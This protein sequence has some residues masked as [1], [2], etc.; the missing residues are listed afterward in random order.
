MEELIKIEKDGNGG[1]AVSARELHAFLGATERFGAWFDRQKQ[2]GFDENLDYSGCK[3]FNALANQELTDY[4]LTLDCAKEIAMLQKSEKGKQARRYFI[5]CEKKLREA[6]L[7]QVRDPKAAALIHAIAKLD[8]VE[9]EQERQAKEVAKLAEE[10]AV[11]E[12]RTQPENRHFT[13]M[14]WARLCGQSLPLER[15]AH[16][17]RKCANLS[18]RRGLP[19]GDVR[20][21]RFGKVHSY[22]ESVLREAFRNP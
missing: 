13:V 7:P 21:P 4:A 17:G 9:Q 5:A 16:I 10:V 3:V 20:G 8:A 18:R 2:Y 6:A 15:A 14:G 22:H 1:G 19:I 11:I 12:A